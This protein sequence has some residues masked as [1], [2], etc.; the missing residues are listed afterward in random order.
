MKK[1][2]YSLIILTSISLLFSCKTS[3]HVKCESYGFNAYSD[4]T[5]INT[6]NW[7]SQKKYS[8]VSAVKL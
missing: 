4:S 3:S 1:F 6:I 7:E 5:D 2:I 8:T